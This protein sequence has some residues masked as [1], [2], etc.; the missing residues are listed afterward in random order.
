MVRVIFAVILL[1]STSTAHAQADLCAQSLQNKVDVAPVGSVVDVPAC[2]YHET[3]YIG[4]S[5]ILDGHNQA[6]INGDWTRDRWVW[7]GA[8]DVAIRNFKMLNAATN[9]QEGAIGTQAGIRNISITGNDLGATRDGEQI[10]IGGTIDSKVVGNSIHDGGQM[11]IGT[12]QNIR[13][14]IQNNHVFHNNTAGIDPYWAAGGIKAINDDDLKIVG[15]ELDHNVGPAIW[16]DIWCNNVV[17]ANNNVHDQR[18]NP[19]FFEISSNADIYGNTITASP[20]GSDMWGCIV[21]SSSANVSVHDN[22]CI[23]TTFLRVQLD[24]RD[25]P[26]N[27]GHDN[28]VQNN[29]L[30]RTNPPQATSWWQY[31]PNGPLVP[32]RNGNVDTGNVLLQNVNTPVATLTPVPT[33]TVPPTSTP[34]PA[35]PTSTPSCYTIQIR[36]GHL[37]EVANC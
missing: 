24:N 19:V 21:S 9:S 2:T 3:V 30:V 37:V 12:Y 29:K 26:T 13:L 8:S 25:A 4:H 18:F 5:V 32:G 15:N 17:I 33:A 23:D 28:V 14:L 16:C 22:T 34:G 36:N 35:Q 31:D 11:G 20:A 1:L 7:I 10:G 6:V 27:A